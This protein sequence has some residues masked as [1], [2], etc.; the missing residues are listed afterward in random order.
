[1]IIKNKP[2]NEIVVE[3]KPRNAG[4]F[5]Y[6]RISGESRTAEQEYRLAEEIESNIKRHVDDVEYTNINQQ[7][8]YVDEEDNEY[9]NLFDL[10]DDHFNE[11]Y[12]RYEYRYVRPS[13]NG[14]GTRS[15]TYDFRDL[16]ESAFRNPNGFEV[17]S[18]HLTDEQKQ[19]LNNVILAGAESKIEWI[20]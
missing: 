17:I 3:V 16:I 15:Y 2:T 8:V 6:I 12:T 18:G 9:N 7:Y 19:F 11:T 13:D 4:N 5:G 20:R 14:V 1:M 10:L